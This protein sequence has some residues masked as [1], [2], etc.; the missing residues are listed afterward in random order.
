MP[1]R[2][3]RASCLLCG[4]VNA[5][6]T[7]HEP[8]GCF[9]CVQCVRRVDPPTE[10]EPARFIKWDSPDGFAVITRSFYEQEMRISR[11]RGAA[12]VVPVR[13]RP[14]MTEMTFMDL[15]RASIRTGCETELNRAADA[16]LRRRG[17]RFNA[18]EQ[19][20]ELPPAAVDLVSPE[21]E[22]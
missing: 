18:R 1:D 15:D 5:P 11:E 13:E 19:K 22:P 17:Y 20:W 4:Q 7:V 9:V 21:R 3:L 16:E 2:D 10:E 8:S 12:S 14:P 6:S